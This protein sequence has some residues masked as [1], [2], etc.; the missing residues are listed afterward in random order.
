MTNAMKKK[1]PS[2]AAI[3]AFEGVGTG[4]AGARRSRPSVHRGLA[5]ASTQG[6]KSMPESVFG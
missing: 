3:D 2:A 6:P 1:E 4:M 5:A